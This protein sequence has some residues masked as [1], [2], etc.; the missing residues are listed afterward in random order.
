MNKGTQS[1]LVK[2]NEFQCPEPT[3][4]KLLT[5]SWELLINT[6][7]SKQASFYD[8]FGQFLNL[9]EHLANE[10]NL[11]LGYFTPFVCFVLIISTP[12]VL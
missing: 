7:L 6:Y 8:A 9:L 3:L 1:R 2:A 5:V 12:S 10:I 11:K 4:E